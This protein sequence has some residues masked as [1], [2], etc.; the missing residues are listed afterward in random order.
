MF[1]AD[2]IVWSMAKDYQNH[3][4]FPIDIQQMAEALGLNESGTNEAREQALK[5]RFLVEKDE[6]L[7]CELTLLLNWTGVTMAWHLPGVLSEEF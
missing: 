1:E 4:R 7:V 5:E 2:Q 3:R 6:E